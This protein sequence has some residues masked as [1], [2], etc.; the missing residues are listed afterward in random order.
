MGVQWIEKWVGLS[1]VLMSF[2]SLLLQKYATGSEPGFALWRL[3]ELE[4]NT[5]HVSR[6]VGHEINNKV[7]TKNKNV[8]KTI[9]V[10]KGRGNSVLESFFFRNRT[11]F[12]S[13]SKCTMYIK[14]A[15]GRCLPHSIQ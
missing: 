11:F 1:A 13:G 2:N 5:Y 15:H 12:T 3:Q 7:M 10:I 9:A 6:E 8:P 4:R 14:T